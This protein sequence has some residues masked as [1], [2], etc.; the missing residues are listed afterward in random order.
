M[1]GNNQPRHSSP[2]HTQ[3]ESGGPSSLWTSASLENIILNL[4]KKYCLLDNTEQHYGT[5]EDLR[6]KSIHRPHFG[7][8][9]DL[10]FVSHVDKTFVTYNNQSA[11]PSTD[12]MDQ[13]GHSQSYRKLNQF[14]ASAPLHHKS[15]KTLS[16]TTQSAREADS[17]FQT[18]TTALMRKYGSAPNLKVSRYETAFGPDNR[19]VT[20]VFYQNGMT[21]DFGHDEEEDSSHEEECNGI[22]EEY[23]TEYKS[24]TPGKLITKCQSSLDVS[25]CSV[26]RES[27]NNSQKHSTSFSGNLN[28]SRDHNSSFVAS[29][30]STEVPKLRSHYD[31]QVIYEHD[32]IRETSEAQFDQVKEPKSPLNIS[33]TNP[34]YGQTHDF[35]KASSSPRMK[36]ETEY[37]YSKSL[38]YSPVKRASSF[39]S[40]TQL[41]EAYGP[42][43]RPPRECYNRQNSSPAINSHTEAKLKIHSPNNSVNPGLAYNYKPVLD[44]SRQDITASHVLMGHPKTPVSSKYDPQSCLTDDYTP[45]ISLSHI[46][47]LYSTRG[48]MYERSGRESTFINCKFIT[49][50]SCLIV[51]LLICYCL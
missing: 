3:E 26:K 45:G 20:R 18:D 7:T 31:D 15:C 38:P 10:R 14:K 27:Q 6:S 34:A 50:Y 17:D 33:T 41:L 40:N 32:Q 11:F 42:G 44:N 2:H 13:L 24:L 37:Q 12:G 4:T 1:A 25:S 48:E 39:Q 21:T 36:E 5:L 43:Y 30:A 22:K 8:Q 28:K 46:T 47:P 51:L 16:R 35:S 19:T 9:E 23:C 29:S 49:L